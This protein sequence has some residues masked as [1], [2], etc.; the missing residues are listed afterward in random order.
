MINH[1]VQTVYIYRSIVLI[2]D[3]IYL[4]VQSSVRTVVCLYIYSS[5]QWI[6]CIFICPYRGLSVFSSV[7]TVDC[8]YIYLSVQQIACIIIC[9]Y[10]GLFVRLY[11]CRVDCLYIILPYSKLSVKLFFCTIC[12]CTF[13]FPQSRL[14]Y[15]Q[16][17]VRQIVCTY[18][19]PYSGLSVYL[20]VST[21]DFLNIYIS[22]RTVDCLFT[23]YS[24]KQSVCTVTFPYRRLSVLQSTLIYFQLLLFI[25]CSFLSFLN[26]F[27]FLLF[28]DNFIYR[29]IY[30]NQSVSVFFQSLAENRIIMLMQGIQDPKLTLDPCLTLSVRNGPYLQSYSFQEYISL[31]PIREEQN[32]TICL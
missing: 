31:N 4:P 3:F 23:P 26:V 5:V 22:V 19:L 8:L 11:F 9:L 15:N 2:D 13:C 6:V 29:E 32:Y 10:S 24:V 1:C 16:L 21:V 27:Y 18:I 14:L 28:Q 20:S 25:I 30:P 7:P 17:S 12:C